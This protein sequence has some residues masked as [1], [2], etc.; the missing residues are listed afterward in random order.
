MDTDINYNITR[1]KVKHIRI[2]VTRDK[3]VKVIIPLKYPV[4]ELN[5]LLENRKDW[6]KKKFDYFDNLRNNFFDLSENEILYLNKKYSFILKPEMKNYFRIDDEG[7]K[8]YSGVDLLNER[9]QTH[10]LKQEAKRVIEERIDILNKDG[11]FKYKKIFIRS[12]KTKWGNC[13]GRGNI[14][15][16]WRLIKAPLYVIDYLIIHEFMHLEEMN[17]SKAFWHKVL[18]ACPDYKG[19]NH[20]LKKYGVGLFY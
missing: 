17:H 12:Q 4:A 19:A 13:S 1:R 16:N 8:I 18:Q 7:M 11:R 9:I 10:W 3:E 6:I 15:F 20:W 2:T 14:S 5:R